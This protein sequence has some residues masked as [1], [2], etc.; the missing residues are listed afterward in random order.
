MQGYYHN[1]EASQRT[2]HNGELH[3]GDI[4]YLDEDGDLFVVQR[5]SDL[6]VSGG[7]NVYPVEVEQVLKQHPGVLDAVVVGLPDVEWG[8]SVAAAVILKLGAVVDEEAL[9]TFCRTHLAGYKV[10][11]R[12]HFVDQ[13]P[14]TASGKI[15][16]PAVADLFKDNA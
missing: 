10:P 8:Q 16:R 9:N 13:F 15:Q 5:R 2:L 1:P 12:F 7:E 4:G 3:T 14:Q 11:R 6:I